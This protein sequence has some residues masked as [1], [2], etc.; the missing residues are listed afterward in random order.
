MQNSQILELNVQEPYFSLIK[1][2]QKTVEGRL[3]KDKYFAFKQGDKL[4]FNGDLETE[5]KTMVK[6]KSFREML[7]FEG[8]KNVL[9]EVQT[10]EEGEQIYY[11]FYTK[12]DE[13]KYGVVAIC[14]SKLLK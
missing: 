4:V 2:G 12:E 10:L 3:G 7:L 11:Q 5:I 9:P 6:Y 1:N 13:Q 8:L 14:L